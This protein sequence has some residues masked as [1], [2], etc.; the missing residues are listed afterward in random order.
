VSGPDDDAGTRPA[1]LKLEVLPGAEADADG[2]PVC[3]PDG[4]RIPEAPEASGEAPRE[5]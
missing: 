3:G 1:P 4:C 2:A 5:D